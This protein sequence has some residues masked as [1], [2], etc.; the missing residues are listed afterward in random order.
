MI[1]AKATFTLAASYNDNP[2]EAVDL[3]CASATAAIREARSFLA[4][5][6]EDHPGEIAEARVSVGEGSLF[7]E[8]NWLGAWEWS[9]RHGWLWRSHQIGRA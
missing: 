4:Q 6:V 5:V 7:E 8:V 3:E 2:A 9:E 1:M